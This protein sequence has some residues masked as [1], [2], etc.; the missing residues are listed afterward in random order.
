M[1][2]ETHAG[3]LERQ[4]D[5]L[6]FESTAVAPLPIGAALLLLRALI[7]PDATA[8]TSV[9]PA[10][11]EARR[12]RGETQRKGSSHPIASRNDGSEERPERGCGPWTTVTV[13]HMKDASS[14]TALAIAS[15]DIVAS[16]AAFA[17]LCLAARVRSMRPSLFSRICEKKI[18]IRC[19]AAGEHAG[20]KRRERDNYQQD[21]TCAEL[22][23]RSR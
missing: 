13:A 7:S 12:G 20:P 23:P 16:L 5:W 14:C 4:F 3:G 10:K 1:D 22:H 9:T 2:E 17:L 8:S 6:F 18:R 11:G 21:S 15:A 19:R